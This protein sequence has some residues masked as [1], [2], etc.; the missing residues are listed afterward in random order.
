VWNMYLVFVAMEIAVCGIYAS[1]FI[2][3]VDMPNPMYS[4]CIASLCV[5]RENCTRH[6]FASSVIIDNALR[7]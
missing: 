7:G 1:V 6:M 4:I 5:G 3:S 2:I